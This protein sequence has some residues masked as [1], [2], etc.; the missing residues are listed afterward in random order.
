M[1]AVTTRREGDRQRMCT[2]G[3]ETKSKRSGTL[4]PDLFIDQYMTRLDGSFIRV[5]LYLLRHY[6]GSNPDRRDNADFSIEAMADSLGCMEKDAH[7]AL[8]GLADAGLLTVSLDRDKHVT[9][10]KLVDLFE[11]PAEEPR[12]SVPTKAPVSDAVTAGVRT[13]ATAA[14]NTD[15]AE[16]EIEKPD[17]RA[18]ERAFSVDNDMIARFSGDSE[19]KDLPGALEGILAGQLTG[20]WFRLMLFAYDR[21]HFSADL[22]YFL[23]EYC[24]EIGKRDAR[25]MTRVAIGWAEN[26][27]S[28]V[29][30]A[31]VHVV[32]FDD[33]SRVVREQFGLRGSF[34][35]LQLDYII[36]WGREWQLSAP[37]VCEACRR[38]MLNTSKSDFRYADKILADWYKKGVRSL[39]D[40]AAADDEH[41]T[42]KSSAAGRK[43]DAAR[44]NRFGDH[45]QREYSESEYSSLELAM[46]NRH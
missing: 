23:F 1:P 26:D 41:A 36:R 27:I 9:G 7:R 13:A 4:I 20:D 18:M 12:R 34:G 42:K 46:R 3:V 16:D 19:Y 5:Y 43:T 15:D 40:V 45:A 25:Y 22:I 17:Y 30:E 10:I 35:K 31:K 44:T 6:F 24:I 33:I 11:V 37:V 28:S 8:R 21:L 2:I 39:D 29:D 14:V 38:T 32:E